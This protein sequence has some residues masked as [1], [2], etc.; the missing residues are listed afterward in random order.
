M[1]LFVYRWK[2]R[3]MTSSLKRALLLQSTSPLE[4]QI[5]MLHEC[6]GTQVK[7]NIE[8]KQHSPERK[9]WKYMGQEKKEGLFPFCTWGNWNPDSLRISCSCFLIFVFV[10][11]SVSYCQS[12]KFKSRILVSWN[13]VPSSTGEKPKDPFLPVE[14]K[15][16][17]FVILS[18]VGLRKKKSPTQNCIEGSKEDVVNKPLFYFCIGLYGKLNAQMNLN[19][20]IFKFLFFVEVYWLGILY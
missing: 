17:L 7:P 19:C 13:Q 10:L 20:F 6:P 9:I 2:W 16:W 5:Q 1:Q 3:C 12:E 11:F 15:K 18:I 14:A 8:V 4:Q